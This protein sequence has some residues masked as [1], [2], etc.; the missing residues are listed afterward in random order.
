[1]CIYEDI[2]ISFKKWEIFCMFIT[3]SNIVK[4]VLWIPLVLS[5]TCPCSTSRNVYYVACN[6]Y[7]LLIFPIPCPELEKKCA[8][9]INHLH[10]SLEERYS[11]ILW[12]RKKNQLLSISII[13]HYLNIFSTFQLYQLWKLNLSAAIGEKNKLED[14]Y[15]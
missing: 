11:I 9:I 14:G 10:S 13:S 5:A 1:M 2:R 8:A 7:K 4:N 15:C 12:A 6:E 3:S